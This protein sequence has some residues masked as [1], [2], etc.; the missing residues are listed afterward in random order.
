MSISEFSV[1]RP[2]TAVM[3]IGIIVVMGTYSFLNLGLDLLPDISYPTVSVLTT[4]TGAA[5]EDMEK[6][7]TRPLESTLAMVSR[8]KKLK[9]STREGISVISVEFEWGTNLDFAAQ[10]IRDQISIYKQMLP[11]DITDPLVFKFDVSMMP[12]AMYSFGGNTDVNRLHDIAENVIK[13]RLERVEGVASVSIWGWDQS[14]V[15]VDVDPMKIAALG[16]DAQQV[17][18][19]LLY[20]NVNLPAG[21]V[22]K[23]AKEHLLRSYGEFRDIGEL[24]KTVVG[25]TADYKPIYLRDIAEIKFGNVMSRGLALMENK[26]ALWIMISKESR[27]NSV[28]VMRKVW[29][30]VDDLEKV[31]PKDTELLTMFDM[32]EPI[33]KIINNTSSNGITGAILAIIF[34]F[35][36][37]RSWRPTVAISV[38]IPISIVATFIAMFAAG[39]TL[40]IMTM[41]GLMLGVG[42]LVDNAIVVI[43]NIYRRIEIGEDRFTAASKGAS[44][45]SMAISASTLTT[46]A[47]FF[48]VLFI[49]GIT[50]Q[51]AKGLALTITFSLLASLFVALT[52]VPVIAANL[53][54]KEKNA[55]KL[56]DQWFH[57]VQNAYGN[58][59]TW[60]LSN[61]KKVLGITAGLFIISL[62]LTP[63]LKGEFMPAQDQPFAQVFFSLPQGTT[64]EDSR[65]VAQQTLSVLENDSDVLV[66]GLIVGVN[67]GSEF[68][69]AMGGGEGTPTNVNEGTLYMRLKDKE[70]R[71]QSTEQITDKLRAAF[72]QIAG[73][74][75]T[76]LDMNS[77]M[78]GGGVG[79]DIEVKLFGD[80]L[81][82]LTRLANLTADEISKLPAISDAKISFKEGRPEMRIVLNKEKCAQLGITAAQVANTVKTYTIGSTAGR[83]VTPK[84]QLDIKIRM[85]ENERRDMAQILSLPIITATGKAIPLSQVAS[86]EEVL[87]PTEIKREDQKRTVVVMTSVKEGSDLRKATDEVT[88]VVN[89]LMTSANW[90]Q[91]N[92]VVI[93]GQAE[94][95]KDL[96]VWMLL[97]VLVAFLLVYMVMASEFES[98]MHPF[99]IM[100]TQPLSIIGVL[101]ALFVTGTAI[102]LPSLMGI[103]ILAGIVVNNGIVMVDFIN[104][105]RRNSNIKIEEAIVTA[106]KLRLRP[107]LITALTTIAGMLPMAFSTSEGSEMRGPIAISVTGGLASATLLTLVVIPIIYIYLEDLRIKVIAGSKRVFGLD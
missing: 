66:R 91:G 34:I 23:R 5:P 99:I 28:T 53:F 46:C 62:A 105:L 80:D 101:L 103:V 88:K 96:Y 93:G 72:P 89:R 106:G 60:A 8:V 92:D 39:Y 35:I 48:P 104:Q 24:G 57:K 50:G 84:E 55:D 59:L 12:V 107:V 13:P 15:H 7:I 1:Q 17:Q 49:P 61:R 3:I 36:F 81:N 79:S 37:L 25:M 52:I 6:Q 67:S 40:N 70:E 75:F 86:F 73:A 14:E 21:Y 64:L 43:E 26:R 69:L 18:M 32:A 31:L 42:M 98:F 20:N 76:V 16:I 10:D 68:D 29:K 51:L 97:A 41:V 63:F 2:V 38:A 19:A 82:T 102:S 94:Q 85:K 30:V 11:E 95:M 27:A 77:Q 74:K 87:G 100:F 56:K 83:F 54:K 90:E 33:T 78:M 71:S 47:V 44:E 22:V 4:W 45:V 9:S 58:A 65:K